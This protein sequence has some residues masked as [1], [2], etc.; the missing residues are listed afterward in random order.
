MLFDKVEV[1]DDVILSDLCRV[2]LVEIGKDVANLTT[3]ITHGSGW[4]ILGIEV[5]TKFDKECFS[6]WIEGYLPEMAAFLK[7]FM[8]IDLAM[9]QSFNVIQ[10]A[11]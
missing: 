4:V 2:L 1:G 3:V 8:Y 6:F 10:E 9:K 5:L 7:S 11:C